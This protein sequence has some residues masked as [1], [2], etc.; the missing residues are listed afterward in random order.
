[1]R[2]AHLEK[3]EN[4][5]T[6]LSIAFFKK[7]NEIPMVNYTVETVTGAYGRAK[8]TRAKSKVH[9]YFVY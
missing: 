5:S 6:E 4:H 8:V 2:R 1:M 3:M 9:I 7:L